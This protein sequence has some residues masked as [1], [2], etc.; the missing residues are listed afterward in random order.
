MNLTDDAAMKITH[1][2]GEDLLSST[3]GKSLCMAMIDPAVRRPVPQFGHLPY[4]MGEGN[5]K[6]RDPSV[7]ADVSRPGYPPEALTNYLPL[8]WFRGR[9]RVLQQ[10]ADG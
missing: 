10:R 2:R 4:V 5:K 7:V 8:G 3:S 1:V 9:C 6:L